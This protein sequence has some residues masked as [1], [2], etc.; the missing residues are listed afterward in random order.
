ME[1]AYEHS[2]KLKEKKNDLS[3]FDVNS[4]IIDYL[5]KCNQSDYSVGFWTILKHISLAYCIN[6]FGLILKSN[7]IKNTIFLDLFSGPGITPLKE[8]DDSK[9]KWIVGSPVISTQMTDYPFTK[10]YFNDKSGKAIELTK[11]ILVELNEKS[12]E[13]RDI[14]FFQEDANVIIKKILPKIQNNY[15]FAFID[16]SGFQWN[17]DSMKLLLNLKRFD[18][19]LNFQTRQIDRIPIE[20]VET[21]FGPCSTEIEN[22]DNCDEKLNVYFDQIKKFNL[23]VISIKIGMTRTNQ[24]YYHLLHIS[25]LGSYKNIIESLKNRIEI[26]DGKSIK[27]IWNDLDKDYF[28]QS[29]F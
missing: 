6:P 23:N 12:I 22:C 3:K 18:I 20:K 14:E 7:N 2:K 29:L 21:F 27:M 15:I 8:L 19:I 16:P 28:Q 17:W 5:N 26:F 10:Y 24:Y 11:K 9:S 25:P 4:D 13:K 1:W